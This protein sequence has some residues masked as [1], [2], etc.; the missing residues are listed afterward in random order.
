[1]LYAFSAYAISLSEQR[2]AFF[3]AE[4][5][6]K[7]GN[8]SS[9]LLEMELLQDY[10][11]YPVLQYQYLSKNLEQEREIQSFLTRYKHSRYADSLRRQWL[12]SMAKQGRW[13]QFMSTYQPT[14]NTSLKCYYHLAQYKTGNRDEAME[15]A[16]KIWLKPYSLPSNCNPLFSVF[17]LSL[18][19]N[20]DVL[21]QRFETAMRKGKKKNVSLAS[22]LI[23]H[24]DASGQQSA[25]LWLKIR[26]K[27]R[28]V[29]QP[30]NWNTRD[31]KAGKIFAQGLH[32]IARKQ[33]DLAISTWNAYQRDFQIDA[34]TRDYVEKR[35]GLVSAYQGNMS[36][37]YHH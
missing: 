21:W 10:A 7:R 1:M 22:S 5:L 12:I 8:E 17:K 34:V 6:I 33:T 37:A 23:K 27:P 25:Q 36:T 2:D 26:R 15:A 18:S 28:L 35:L 32:L 14:K 16:K 20:Q 31:P 13:S 30:S 29:T 4:K 24:M 3:R 11:L 9:F 19:Y